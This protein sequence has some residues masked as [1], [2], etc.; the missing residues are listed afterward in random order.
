M[1]GLLVRGTIFLGKEKDLQRAVA[2]SGSGLCFRGCL[3]S[4]FCA[5]KRVDNSC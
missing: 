5:V 1:N 4:R 2:I 3:G